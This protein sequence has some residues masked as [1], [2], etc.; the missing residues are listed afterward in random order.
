[1]MTFPNP[2][3]AEIIA[4]V[5]ERLRPP[6][7][8]GRDESGSFFLR[9]DPPLTAQEQARVDAFIGMVR[10]PVKVDPEE[11]E[12]LLPTLQQ[13]RAFRTRT[14]APTNAQVLATMDNIID[15]LRAL[16]RN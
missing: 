12:A 2:Q 13:L 9:F 10:S 11:W 14:S 3:D 1:M 5:S 6:S 7:E 16:L 4:L 8:Y 15:V